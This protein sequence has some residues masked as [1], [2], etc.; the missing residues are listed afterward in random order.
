[1]DE[2][3]G[4]A[5]NPGNL[6][7][8]PHEAKDTI[9]NELNS[10]LHLQR[11]M[12]FKLEKI[13]GRLIHTFVAGELVRSMGYS[14]EQVIGK[15]IEE[16]LPPEYTTQ[17][18]H[19]Y[20]K[21][22]AGEEISY[23]GYMNGI[24]YL[25]SLKPIVHNG[26]VTEVIATCVDITEQKKTE[27]ELR[28][29]KELLE[30]IINHT[31][32]AIGVFDLQGRII[33]ANPAFEVMYG[34]DREEILGETLPIIPPFKTEE[35]KRIMEEVK[36][37][38]VI[39]GFETI[40]QKKDGSFIEI[41]ASYSPVRDIQ[42]EIIGVSFTARDVTEHNRT[43]ELLRKSDRLSIIGQLAASVAHE[44]RNPLTALKGFLQL[45]TTGDKNNPYYPIMLDEMNRIEMITNEF[46]VLAK[47]QAKA[48]ELNSLHEILRR[49]I[50]L[51]QIQGLMNQVDIQTAF[52][53]DLPPVLCNQ[54]QIIQVFLNVIKNA[55]EAMPCG[56]TI[57]ISLE[58]LE[59]GYLLVQVIDQGTGIPGERISRLGEPFY[60]T[61]EK[62]T[63]LGLLVSYRI[64]EEHN[65]K[66]D[67]Y[68]EIGKGTL[69]NIILPIHSPT[70]QQKIE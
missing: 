34:W 47:P 12:T 22:W 19:Y 53:P 1:M 35:T 58:K 11:G 27:E 6:D 33:Q 42:G 51:A 40:R 26:S 20:E 32:D 14:C 15:T 60:S 39:K 7:D 17:K 5:K 66:I 8:M 36:A 54:N 52:E 4:Y 62:G 68:S 69:V 65:G 38:N 48:Y 46:L 2:D 30:S 50:T 44:I 9:H 63:G 24:H 23:E 25:A 61:K 31:A 70:E 64:I 49:V 55:I 56:G 18:N 28:K 59:P 41:S 16:F 10:L 57:T 29:T 37:G 43:A 3:N 67:I 21:A 45:L 13:N